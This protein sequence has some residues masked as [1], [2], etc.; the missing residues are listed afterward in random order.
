MTAASDE[1]CAIA[2]PDVVVAAEAR[3]HIPVVFHQCVSECLGINGGLRRTGKARDSKPLQAESHV[4]RARF[5]SCRVPMGTGFLH[6]GKR[7]EKTNSVNSN[8]MRT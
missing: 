6:A 2:L 3:H 7:H 5:C 8:T 4:S 1:G